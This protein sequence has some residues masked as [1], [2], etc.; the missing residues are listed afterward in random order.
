MNQPTKHELHGIKVVSWDVDGTLYD[1]S[2]MKK[3]L[4]TLWLSAF[5]RPSTWRDIKVILASQKMIK[6]IHNNGGEYGSLFNEETRRL[7]ERAEKRW[8]HRALSQSGLREGIVN[9]VAFFRLSGLQQIV[10]S[11]YRADY[12]LE[13]LGIKREFQHAYACEDHRALKPSSAIFDLV[14]NELGV[15]PKEILHIGDRADTDGVAAKK[16]GCQFYHLSDGT[17]LD[18]VNVLSSLNHSE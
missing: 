6:R 9:A 13:I 11:D 8:F 4:V 18:V 14:C 2:V 7:A 17:L 3:H 1:S 15:L 12:K 10:V 16:A 5:W